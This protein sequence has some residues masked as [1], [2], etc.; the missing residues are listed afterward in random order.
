MANKFALLS[1]WTVE[2]INARMTHC[3]SVQLMQIL[4]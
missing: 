4:Y 2:A 1:A 3:A